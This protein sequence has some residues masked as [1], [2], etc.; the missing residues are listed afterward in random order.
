MT[1]WRIVAAAVA[2]GLVVVYAIGSG[3]WVSTG[4]SWYVSLEQPA[5]QPPPPVFGLA[6]SYNFLALA[7]V[8][9][10]MAA[11]GRPVR[12]ALF[13]VSLAASIVLAIGWA[14]LFYGPHALVGAAVALTLAAL[15]TVVPVSVAF[16]ERAWL[17]WLL[18]PYL[19]WLAIATSLSWGYVALR[20]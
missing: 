9:V 3:R 15:V 10:A 17:G 4:S 14:Y 16:V 18:V 1:A 19:A 5:W 6:W 8:G 2:V 7:V 13:L 12:V 11:Q 20:A